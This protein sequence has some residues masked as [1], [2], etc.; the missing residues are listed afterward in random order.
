MKIK[1]G[2]LVE[3]GIK[4]GW[5]EVDRVID[6]EEKIIVSV[7]PNWNKKTY[8]FDDVISVYKKTWE[9]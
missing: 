8:C 3:L 6:N 9:R 1:I 4:H 5:F 2:D 7:G